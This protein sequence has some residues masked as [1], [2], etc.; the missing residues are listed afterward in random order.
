MGNV[1]FKDLAHATAL[2]YAA[3]QEAKKGDGHQFHASS[4]LGDAL[5]AA[6]HCS[7]GSLL[8][9]ELLLSHLM[10]E[11]LQAYAVEYPDSPISMPESTS[12]DTAALTPLSKPKLPGPTG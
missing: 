4:A 1:S 9:A 8:E 10:S 11:L 2:L 6:G 12:A 3:I 5:T 7:P